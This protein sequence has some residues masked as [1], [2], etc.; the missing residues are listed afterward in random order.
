LYFVVFD[1]AF[2]SVLFFCWVA[3]FSHPS[4]VLILVVLSFLA[5][6]LQ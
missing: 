2:F 4:L 1:P 5:L 3:F 6:F